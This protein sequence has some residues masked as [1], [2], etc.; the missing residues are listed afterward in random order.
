MVFGITG[1]ELVTHVEPIFEDTPKDIWYT[2]YIVALYNEG[3]VNG[4]SDTH[5][6]VGAYATRQDI[7]TIV[8]RILELKGTGETGFTDNYKIADYAVDAV[9]ALNSKS[10][11]NGYPDGTFN[12]Y[13][14]CTRAEAATII[15]RASKFAEVK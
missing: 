4:V 9:S 3:L 11:V 10:I 14:N 1:L 5:F 15:Y 8:N 2:D 13:G 7:C 6:G 12:P